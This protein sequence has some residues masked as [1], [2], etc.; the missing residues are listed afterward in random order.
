MDELRRVGY[1]TQ[2]ILGHTNAQYHKPPRDL[3]Q[4]ERDELGKALLNP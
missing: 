1:T 3:T 4:T 2:E